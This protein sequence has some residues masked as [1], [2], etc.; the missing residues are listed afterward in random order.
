MTEKDKSFI[1]KAVTIVA[2][3]GLTFGIFVYINALWEGKAVFPE[4]LANAIVFLLVAAVSSAGVLLR[5][6]DHS[7]TRQTVRD[8]EKHITHAL[9]NSGGDAIAEKVKTVM[10]PAIREGDRRRTVVP[11]ASGPKRRAHDQALTMEDMD[12]LR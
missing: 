8:A 10:E 7:E 2:S 11:D 3:I 5:R 1:I 6:R 4:Q 12:Q 9:E